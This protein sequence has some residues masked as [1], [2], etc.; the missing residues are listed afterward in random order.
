MNM[1]NGTTWARQAGD[2]DLPGQPLDWRRQAF[3]IRWQ[4]RERAVGLITAEVA[5]G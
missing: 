2:G 4:I 5:H 3:T 1:D